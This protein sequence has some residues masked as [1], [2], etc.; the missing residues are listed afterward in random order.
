MQDSQSFGS[1]STFLHV[2]NK[3]L[4]DN[5]NKTGSKAIKNQILCKKIFHKNL[6]IGWTIQIRRF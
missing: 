2:F 5:Q 1:E 3:R 6:V 4:A